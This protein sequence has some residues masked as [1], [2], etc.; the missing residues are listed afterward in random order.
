[1]QFWDLWEQVLFDDESTI[2]VDLTGIGNKH[3]RYVTLDYN[4]INDGEHLY[5]LIEKLNDHKNKMMEV[6]NLSNGK[7]IKSFS[8]EKL[9]EIAIMPGDTIK[10]E[11]KI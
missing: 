1:M 4:S 6:M 3:L 7:K 5:S 8:N 9:S 10:V 2:E 11:Y